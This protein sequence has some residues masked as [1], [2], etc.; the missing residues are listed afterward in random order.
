MINKPMKSFHLLRIGT[1]LDLR[2]QITGKMYSVKIRKFN[3]LILKNVIHYLFHVTD[4][5]NLIF[6]KGIVLKIY[7]TL[8]LYYC[9][10]LLIIQNAFWYISFLS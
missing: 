8:E 5:I 2:I 1:S 10:L 6:I 7:S 3:N 4:T 9:V